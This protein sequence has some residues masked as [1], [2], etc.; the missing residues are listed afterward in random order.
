LAGSGGGGVGA[1]GSG[2]ISTIRG[3]SSS[4]FVHSGRTCFFCDEADEADEASTALAAAP[5]LF[6]TGSLGGVV[7][8]GGTFSF[9]FCDGGGGAGGAAGSLPSLDATTRRP[10]VATSVPALSLSVAISR[11]PLDRKTVGGVTR[12]AVIVK[13]PS[14]AGASLSCT[15]TSVCS[16]PS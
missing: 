12:M 1:A 5:V 6:A 2:T 8:F 9:F 7:G 13:P 15:R 14:A 3:S 10:P 11:A 16:L 4:I